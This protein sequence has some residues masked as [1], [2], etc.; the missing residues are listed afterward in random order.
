MDSRTLCLG[1]LM[2]GDAS[3]YEIKKHFEEGPFAHI[4]ATGFGSIYPALGA[5]LS[6][7]LVTCTQMSQD[8]RP[9]KKIYSITDDGRRAFVR[10]LHRAPGPDTFR[11]D[12]VFML[13]FAELLDR[14]HLREVFDEY[15]ELHRASVARM[16][17]GECVG[18]SPG[19][20]FVHGLGLAI[21]R[22]IAEYM[23][24]HRSELLAPRERPSGDTASVVD[25]AE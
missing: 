17:S 7:G 12:A 6:D 1:V 25:A 15:L 13:F 24:H 20:D 4:H 14:D 11:S 22:A 5:L 9:D 16:S 10:A 19:H 18:S 3:G 23:E 2:L 8:G 21:Y